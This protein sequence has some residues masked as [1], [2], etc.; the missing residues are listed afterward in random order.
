MDSKYWRE[1]IEAKLK[2]LS[3]DDLK[4]LDFEVMM[5]RRSGAFRSIANGIL[6]DLEELEGKCERSA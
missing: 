3:T 2:E 5:A 6:R 4:G 1:K